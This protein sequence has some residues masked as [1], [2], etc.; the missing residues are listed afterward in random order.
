LIRLGDHGTRAAQ[1]NARIGA[2]EGLGPDIERAADLEGAFARATG[3]AMFTDQGASER[4]HGPCAGMK[5]HV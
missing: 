1:K 2:A 3:R 5:T 4:A